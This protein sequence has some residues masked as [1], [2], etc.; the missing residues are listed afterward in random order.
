MSVLRPTVGEKDIADAFGSLGDYANTQ[1]V[2]VMTLPDVV[3][4]D[5]R[6][7]RGRA[8]LVRHGWREIELLEIW[9]RSLAAPH[10]SGGRA[11][12]YIREAV[13]D[14][15]PTLGDIAVA[16]FDQDRLHADVTVTTEEANAAKVEW[17]GRAFADWETEGLVACPDRKWPP[18][19]FAFFKCQSGRV[20]VDLI[21]VEKE[22]RG[23]NIA[24]ALVV[25]GAKLYP[26]AKDMQAGTQR[27]NIPG[28]ALYRSLGFEIAEVWRTFHKDAL[29]LY[30]G[31]YTIAS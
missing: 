6:D 26:Q 18:I 20:M 7:E 17:V 23:K 15:L 2:M 21:A 10:M 4:I 30:P 13:P 14:D 1:S 11:E 22:H 29:P 24:Q 31:G 28:R 27:H 3:R 8:A 5:V 25:A 16:A 9:R 12:C 19:A